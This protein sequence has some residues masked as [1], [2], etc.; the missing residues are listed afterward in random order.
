MHKGIRKSQLCRGATCQP[1]PPNQATAYRHPGVCV[2][3]WQPALLCSN[4]PPANIR[5][6]YREKIEIYKRGPEVEVDFRHTKFFSA[7]DTPPPP[8]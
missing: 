6:F 1:R 8:R 7:S 3:K 4:H 2:W 5:K